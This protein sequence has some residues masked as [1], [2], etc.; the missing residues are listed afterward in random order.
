MAVFEEYRRPI[1][2]RLVT[3]K[4]KHWDVE[5][6]NLSARSLHFLTDLDPTYMIQKVLPKLVDICLADDL[7]IRHGAM[8]GIAEITNALGKLAA[9]KNGT[10]SDIGLD[11]KL[12]TSI[13]EIVPKIEH[14][15]LYRGRGGEIMRSA[16]CRL[17]ECI[18]SSHFDV[19]VKLQVRLLDSIDSSLSHPNEDVQAAA[20][21]SL[22]ALLA[23][24][25]PVSASGPSERLQKRV[26]D[27]YTEILDTESNAAATRGSALALGNLPKKLV[28]PNEVVLD[29]VLECLFRACHQDARVGGEPDAETRRNA[30]ISLRN[31]C[32]TVG[33]SSSNGNIS[34]SPIKGMSKRHIARVFNVFLAAL[35]DYGLDNRGDVGSWSRIA[36]IEGLEQLTYLATKSSD[37]T[38]SAFPAPPFY[39]TKPGD[40]AV[41]NLSSRLE[42]FEVDAQNRVT[43]ALQS[44]KPLRE[45]KC[46]NRQC[47][48]F[49]ET[50]CNRIFCALLK[51]L[52]EKMDTV[53]MKAGESIVRLLKSVNPR[54]PFIPERSTL[55]AAL[56]LVDQSPSLSCQFFVNNRGCKNEVHTNWANAAKTFP[57]M[58]KAVNIDAYFADIISGIVISVGGLSESIVKNSTSALLAWVRT[59]NEVAAVG[60][61]GRLG[62]VLLKLFEKHQKE[63]RVILPLLKTIE[64]LISQRSLDCLLQNENS[65]FPPSLVDHL[66]KEARGCKDVKRL[67]GI[68]DVLVGLV[69]T[70]HDDLVSFN[71]SEESIP[72]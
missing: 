22:K 55:L 34:C 2:E 4:L 60:R 41:P 19:P 39:H 36:A 63:G 54:I 16:A 64:L 57:L 67:L 53:R 72:L 66:K 45:D 12:A 5:I 61:I 71:Y 13:T 52:S 56:C 1:I 28:A 30:V 29:R 15:R 6:R 35:D 65:G 68:A 3:D 40:V 26:V 25:F 62:G 10:V 21:L 46:K 59:L 43:V 47:I 49:D 51:Q 42:Y 18:A 17:I 14:A 70:R 27:K 31:V 8:I 50:I 7:L 33:I 23:N 24:H 20:S 44:D 58:M 11:E 69:N 48:Y 37:A 32:S 9:D 38:P